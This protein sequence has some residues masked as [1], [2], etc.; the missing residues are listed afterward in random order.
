MPK[1]FDKCVEEGGRVVTIKPKK[2]YY[3]HIC[4][5]KKGNSHAGEVKEDKKKNG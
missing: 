1:S 4:W 2:G 3:M 5:D